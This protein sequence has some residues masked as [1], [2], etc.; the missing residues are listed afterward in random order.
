MA[1]LELTDMAHETIQEPKWQTKRTDMDM[2]RGPLRLADGSAECPPNVPNLSSRA[3]VP[4]RQS[5]GMALAHGIK[6]SEIDRLEELRMA[7]NQ[8]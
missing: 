7:V 6:G 2:S 1:S 4:S 5:E 8:S 3:G